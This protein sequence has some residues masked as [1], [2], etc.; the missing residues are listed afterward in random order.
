MKN[1]LSTIILIFIA[2]NS[3]ADGLLMPKAN[4]Y[5]KDFLR[6]KIT[7]ITV[8]INGIIAETI[9]YQEFVNESNDTID[10]VY[11]FPLPENARANDLIYWRHDTIFKAVLKVQ[12]QVVNP[13]TGEGGIAA[14]VNKYLGKNGIRMELKQIPPHTIQKVELHYVSMIDYHYGLCTYKYPLNTG[15]FVQY[16]IDYLKCNINI[17]STEKI[18]GFDSPNFH[19]Y[20]V[21][22]SDA[23]NLSV[24]Y[25]KPK[26]YLAKD[27]VFTY[28]ISNDDLSIN[29]FSSKEDSADGHF[30]LFVRPQMRET[31]AA[32]PKK[33]VFLVGNSSRMTGAKLE[34]S[35]TAIS[36]SLNKLH[37]TDYFNIV[38]FNSFVSKWNEN[39]LP[40]NGDNIAEAQ[41][42]LK[43]I[44][45]E[46]GSNLSDGLS[47]ALAQIKDEQYINSILVFTDG[48]SYIDPKAIALSNKYK[49]GLFFVG[50]GSDIDRSRLEMTASLNYGFVT[51]INENENLKDGVIKVFEKINKPILKN[52]SLDFRKPDIYGLIPQLLPTTYLGSYFFVSG[53]YKEPSTSLLVL[54]GEGVTGIK[55]YEFNLNFEGNTG[56]NTFA[57]YIWAKD[58]IDAL[59][60]EIKIYGENQQL[61]DSLISLSLKYNIRC[62]YTAYIADYKTVID[63]HDDETTEVGSSSE[64]SSIFETKEN[65]N[66]ENSFIYNNFPNPFVAET[67]FKIYISPQSKSNVKLLKFFNAFGQLIGV[68]D[69]TSYSEGWN[70]ITVNFNNFNGSLPS[71]IYYASL[72]EDNSIINTIKVLYKKY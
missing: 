65:S 31:K 14:L 1:K 63:D 29:F 16:P 5:P 3:L 43:T 30:N 71:G 13:G 23:N 24:E 64:H 17:K 11:S 62:R 21:L 54:R 42:Y 22:Q 68:I 72:Q 20:S 8:N 58:V 37:S 57:Q 46:Y 45:A 27:F 26:A 38:L 6:N 66:F 69:I 39:L 33:I 12:Q 56:K 18:E 67:T 28:N 4:T 10:A 36:E 7:E 60:Y 61:K 25:L 19:Q 49:T 50:I 40:A 35:L 55:S 44:H 53:C 34:Q 70:T 32:I 48:I 59:E 47:V 9:V 2:L 51:Y 15:Q 52:V 41:K